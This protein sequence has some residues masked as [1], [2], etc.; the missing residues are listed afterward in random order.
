M[1]FGS[2]CPSN[3]AII[4][5][6]DKLFILRVFIMAFSLNAVAAANDNGID[7]QAEPR[8]DHLS[9]EL[10][11]DA[12]QKAKLEAIFTEKHEKFRAIR[13]Q[14]Q[15]NIREILSE[16]QMSKWEDLRKQRFAKHRK[17]IEDSAQAE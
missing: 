4:C 1:N 8:M 12:D 13:E 11:L 17:I 10:E 5:P 9:R 2:E 3:K 16:E 7:G 14:F 6:M 15:N